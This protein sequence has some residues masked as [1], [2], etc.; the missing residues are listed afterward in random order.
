M[1]Y[2]VGLLLDSGLVML[3]DT[4]TNAGFD[5]IA[6]YRKMFAFESPGERVIV[7]LTAGNLSVTQ[8]VV[9][10]LAHETQRE[11]AGPDTSILQAGTMLEVA[12]IVGRTLNDVSVE[13]GARMARSSSWLQ[14]VQLVSMVFSLS[15]AAPNALGSG[16]TRLKLS[17]QAVKS[18]SV[19]KS[20]TSSGGGVAVASRWMRTR[21]SRK[22]S[23]W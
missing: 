5:N 9:A 19:G 17:R 7:L 15:N 3:S 6:C 22:P 1:T 20:L 16:A 4:R 21:S 12:E 14:P 18:A 10:K 13:I 23:S 8:T 11:G 2:C